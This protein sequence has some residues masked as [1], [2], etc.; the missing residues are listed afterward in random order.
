MNA[1]QTIAFDQT[2]LWRQSNCTATLE[3]KVCPSAIVT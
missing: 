2:R 1:E 3:N